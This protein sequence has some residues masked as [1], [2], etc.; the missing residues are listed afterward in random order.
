M[1]ALTLRTA[2]SPVSMADSLLRLS[3]ATSP[4]EEYLAK[5]TLVKENVSLNLLLDYTGWHC[6]AQCCSVLIQLCA[7]NEND[8]KTWMIQNSTHPTPACHRHCDCHIFML[9]SRLEVDGN[10]FVVYDALLPACPKSKPCFVIPCITILSAAVHPAIPRQQ[11]TLVLERLQSLQPYLPQ[12][13]FNFVGETSD[14]SSHHTP[15]LR[16]YAL[17][18]LK[19]IATETTDMVW[20]RQQLF[21]LNDMIS[22]TMRRETKPN[23]VNGLI[24]VFEDDDGKL[25]SATKCMMGIVRDLS[26]AAAAHDLLHE[27]MRVIRND[28]NVLLDWMTSDEET[29]VEVLTLLL[30]YLKWE[31]SGMSESV[32]R[33]LVQLRGSVQR[34]VDGKVF[35]YNAE[36]L[37]RRM[38]D[39]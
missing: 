12:F 35:P 31:R 18:Y 14:V 3:K 4:I 10:L 39:L 29:S 8:I 11:L 1:P 23:L 30:A 37:L 28:H 5:Q 32:R 25:L 34:L 24:E 20:K 27:L 17:T 26:D 22:N 9:M 36:P 19:V 2:S 15:Q 13:A 21:N 16:S 38:R 6:L 33:V 7:G